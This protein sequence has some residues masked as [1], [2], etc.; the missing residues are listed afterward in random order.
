MT[1]KYTHKHHIV[2]LHMGGT[3]HSSNIAVLSIKQHAQAHKKLFIEHLN[4]LDMEAYISLKRMIG[5]E[6][7]IWEKLSKPKTDTHKANISKGII[8][9]HKK[10]KENKMKDKE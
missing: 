10:R 4:W 6:K 8:E 9:W 1:K 2:P 7:E 3:D 5:R